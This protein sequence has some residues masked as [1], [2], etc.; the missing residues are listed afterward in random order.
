MVKL[1]IVSKKYFKVF[2]YEKVNNLCVCTV[3]GFPVYEEVGI[4]WSFLNG[5]ISKVHNGIYLFGI[6]I[7]G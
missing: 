2:R 4:M 7:H 5:F 3:F 1:N 6:K